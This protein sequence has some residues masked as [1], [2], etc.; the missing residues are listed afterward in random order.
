VGG[1]QSIYLKTLINSMINRHMSP[2]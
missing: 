2:D 1:G